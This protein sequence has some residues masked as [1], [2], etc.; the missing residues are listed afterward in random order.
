MQWQW[1]W[2]CNGILNT[3]GGTSI[4]MRFIKRSCWCEKVRRRERS[5]RE[6]WR[7]ETVSSSR[8]HPDTKTAFSTPPAETAAASSFSQQTSEA[9]DDKRGRC[10]TAIQ[11]SI[12]ILR[13]SHC[14]SCSHRMLN[15]NW[16]CMLHSIKIFLTDFTLKILKFHKLWDFYH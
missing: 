15:L 2:Q 4:S 6:C 12:S 13:D 1:Q 3:R 8:I 11:L 9:T 10:S 7:S 5:A 16:Y 14:R